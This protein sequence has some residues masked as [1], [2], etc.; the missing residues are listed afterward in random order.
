MAT[1]LLK[2]LAVISLMA[3]CELCIPR[4]GNLLSWLIGLCAFWNLCAWPVSSGRDLA[5]RGPVGHDG[6]RPGM[7]R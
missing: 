4:L 3:V 2:A 6:A 1:R 7:A 5:S